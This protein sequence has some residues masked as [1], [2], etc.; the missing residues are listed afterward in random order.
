MKWLRVRT[1]RCGGGGL[2]VLRLD[3]LSEDSVD[4]NDV[5][6][7]AELVLQLGQPLLRGDLLSGQTLHLVLV[8]L[9]FTLQSLP[10]ETQTA[11]MRTDGVMVSLRKHQPRKQ[12]YYASCRD[13]KMLIINLSAVTSV[14]Q[15]SLTSAALRFS[16]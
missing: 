9:L 8:L 2:V 11:A 12:I 4:L 6:A 13:L 14:K 15:Q 10:G 3:G 5:H 1:R 7:L 16:S